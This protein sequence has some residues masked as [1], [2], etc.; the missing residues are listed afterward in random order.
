MKKIYSMIA[1]IALVLFPVMLSGQDINVTG[2]WEM[3]LETPRGERTQAIHIEQDGEKLI[4][5]MQGGMR[6]GQGGG[7]ITAEGT[8]QGNKVEWSFSRNTPRGDFS[9]KYTGTVE[10]DTMTGEVSRGQSR[11]SPWT[12]KRI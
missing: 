11:T 5:T 7:E 8:I 1:M 10:G 6:G 3:T 4:V 2:D 12:A 9:I